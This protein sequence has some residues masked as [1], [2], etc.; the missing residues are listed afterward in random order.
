MGQKFLQG[1]ERV[2]VGT[3]HFLFL[4]DVTGLLDSLP[5]EAGF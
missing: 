2:V 1:L 3:Q 5:V 4:L